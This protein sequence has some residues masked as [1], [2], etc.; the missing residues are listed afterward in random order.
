MGKRIIQRAR[1]KGGPRYRVRK[2]AFI[3]EV[4]YPNVEGKGRIIKLISSQA[5][6]A[7]LMKIL[8]SGKIF[9]NPAFR[10]AFEGQEINIG[11]IENSS[12]IGDILK[13][14]EIPINMQVYN[15]ELKP[16]DGGKAVRASGISGTLTKK[17][18]G[19]VAVL[20]PSKKEIWFDENCRASIGITAGKGKFEK[21]IGKAGRMFYIKKVK[22]GRV[23]PR[24]SAVKMNI[25]DHPFGSGRGKRIKSKIPKRNAPPGAKVGSL[26][27]RRTGRRK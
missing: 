19:K 15:L 17:I 12:V 23:W 1:G 5:H 10:G 14:K 9:Y 13:L 20:M 27:P 4:K 26:R 11:K 7:P 25:I 22:G 6:S 8:V 18:A 24:T 16:G 2:R 3:F 21:P